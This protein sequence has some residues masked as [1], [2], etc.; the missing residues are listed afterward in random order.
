MTVEN[1]QSRYQHKLVT[2]A[3][4]VGKIESGDRVAVGHAC[5]EPQALVRALVARSAQLRNVE[6]IHMVAMGESAYAQPGMESSFR[7]NALFVGRSTRKAVEEGR[8]D[9]TPCFFRRFPG[10]LRKEY[11]RFRLL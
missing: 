8:A 5:G 6:I 3:E 1:W 10:C 4:A 2:A 11:C 9:Y 7:H